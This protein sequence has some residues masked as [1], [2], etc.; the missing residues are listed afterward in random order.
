M[1]L[2]DINKEKKLEFKVSN[3]D[4]IKDV[5][6]V[7]NFPDDVVKRFPGN[8]IKG[9]NEVHITI[10]SMQD[11]IKEQIELQCY[12]EIEDVYGA[13]HKLSQDTIVFKFLPVIE[14]VFHDPS[15]DK[16]DVQNKK[17]AYVDNI[18]INTPSIN[19]KKTKKLSRKET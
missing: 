11:I 6:L 12:L 14:V 17:E 13:F 15:G 1:I 8:V 4:S 19:S 7:I 10:P 3:P 2:I 16:V 9:Q 5:Q 18:I